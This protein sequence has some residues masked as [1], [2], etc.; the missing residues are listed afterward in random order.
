MAA[1]VDPESGTMVFPQLKNPFAHRGAVAKETCLEPPK[2]NSHLRL[3][4]L[5]VNGL[6]PLR[7]RQAAVFRLVSEEFEHPA[8]VAY[9]L[10][11]GK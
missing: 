1:K 5:V 9:K 3:G 7:E 11:S 8:I 6:K 10:H 4:L 2:P